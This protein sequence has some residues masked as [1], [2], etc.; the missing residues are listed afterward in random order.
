MAWAFYAIGLDKQAVK[1]ARKAVAVVGDAKQSEYE[2]HL[3]KL[4]AGVA[5]TLEAKGL[6]RIVEIDSEL[7]AHRK[8][9]EVRRARRF[10][11]PADQ[12]LHS[13]LRQLVSAPEQSPINRKRSIPRRAEIASMAS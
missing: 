5:A 7:R 9:D 3:E 10:A 2:D 6:T 1:H 4:E 11:D 8:E 13:A 12:F